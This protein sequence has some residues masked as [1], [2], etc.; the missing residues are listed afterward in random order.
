[1][2]SRP[3][4]AAGGR[5]GRGATG[6]G[7]AFCIARATASG[8]KAPIGRTGAGGFTGLT[9]IGTTLATLA[10]LTGFSTGFTTGF[11]A[12]AGFSTAFT[13]LAGLALTAVGLALVLA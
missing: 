13:G 11:T 2:I 7:G 8:G 1:M 9:F 5:P 10:G 4:F 6:V 3:A 12:F